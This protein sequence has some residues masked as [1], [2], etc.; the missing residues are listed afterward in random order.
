MSGD[1]ELTQRSRETKYL[2]QAENSFVEA[3]ST[4]DRAHQAVMQAQAGLSV[5]EIQWA[6]NM[7]EEALHQIY[8]AQQLGHANLEAMAQ[9]QREQHQL[10]QEYQLF[11]DE[12]Q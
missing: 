8:Q 10:L 1:D 4:A 6:Q 9:L 7:V 12:W 3:I 2:M 11:T 5:Q